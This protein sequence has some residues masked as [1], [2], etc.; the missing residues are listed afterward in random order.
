MILRAL[1]TILSFTKNHWRR[2]MGVVIFSAIGTLAALKVFENGVDMGRMVGHC[3]LSCRVLGTEFV[4]LDTDTSCQCESPG[5]F[6][7]GIPMDHSY[8]DR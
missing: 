8:F 7:I 1:G 5:G 4:A 3:E 6:I 2:V